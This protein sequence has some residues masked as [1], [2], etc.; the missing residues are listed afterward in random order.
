MVRTQTLHDRERDDSA[1]VVLTLIVLAAL[2]F[3]IYVLFGRFH[4]RE[5]Q[6]VE[7]SIYLACL[8]GAAYTVIRYRLTYEQKREE[9]W[10]R[11]RISISPDRHERNIQAALASDSIVIGYDIDTEQPVVWPDEVRTMQSILI[12][13]S[14]FGKSTFL[15]NVIAQ[16]A[17]RVFDIGGVKR[18]MPMIIL[19]GKGDREFT[20]ELLEVFAAAGRLGDVRLLDPARPDL[21]VR[22]NALYSPDDESYQQHLEFIFGSFGL[23]NDFFSGHQ[24]NYFN[25][26]GRILRHTG[27]VHNVYDVLVVAFDPIVLREQ[28]DV[29]IRRAENRSDLSVQQR[30]NL[31]MSARNLMQSLQDQDRVT[32]IQG[33][34]NELMT[35][36]ADD[37]SVITGAYDRL[38]T[39]DQV[40][41]EDL[42][43]LISLDPNSSPKAI[44]AL[45]R[46]LLHNLQLVVGKRYKRNDRARQGWP[47]AS[48]VLDEF[49]PFVYPNFTR[50]LQTARGSNLS[51]LFSLQT[52]A[53]LENISRSFRANVTAAP[54]TI[55]LMQ[56][57]DAESATYFQDA[58]STVRVERRNLRVRARGLFRQQYDPTG[59]ATAME[60][61]EARVPMPRIRKLPRG[62][63][64]LLMASTRG[65]PRYAHLH[66][67][68]P[69]RAKLECFQPMVYPPIP[70]SNWR[71]ND[72]ANLRF[73]DTELV[74]RLARISGRRSR[75]EVV[76]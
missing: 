28:I 15:R 3:G 75:Y 7:A 59:D 41:D 13:K 69:S 14:G 29:A 46:I 74:K 25:D 48:I 38:L 2:G 1:V 9:S 65:E 6:L 73:K 72:G 52:I 71:N 63:M 20:N 64:H 51:F 11:V 49:E 16:D 44:P 66:I 8:A 26:L 60:V 40:F 17:R 37:L 68:S 43:L 56:G 55:M 50:V 53:Q 54:S 34:L 21:S 30:L 33:L 10:P 39:L 12:G 67:P 4:L 47:M 19:G 23:R 35:F 70:S 31:Q 18:R 24:A 61:D 45:G 58:A 57:W 76:I 5:R 27:N 62:Q 22:Y 32:K 42:I 36:L